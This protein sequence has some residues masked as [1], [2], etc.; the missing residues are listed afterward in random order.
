MSKECYIIV[1]D[2][3]RDNC[4]DQFKIFKN[5]ANLYFLYFKSKND[6][7]NKDYTKYGKA[8]F[9][10]DFHD[11]YALIKTIKVKKVF[12][13]SLET[14][15]EVALNVACKKTGIKTYHIEHGIRNLVSEASE[16][17]IIHNKNTIIKLL[18]PF[19]IISNIKNRRFFTNTIKNST[20]ED[21]FNLKNY[22][23]IRSVNGIEDTF[24]KVKNSYRIANHYISFSSEIYKYHFIKDHLSKNQLVNF[25]GVPEFD[26]YSSINIQ[27]KK[28]CNNIIY[29]SQPFVEKGV[30]GWTQE[31]QLSLIK[32][33]S[34][35]LEPRK[36][37]IF[38]KI[39]PKSDMIFWNKVAKDFKNIILLKDPNDLIE[40]LKFNRLIFGFSSTLL[41]PLIAQKH[42]VCFSLEKHPNGQ[43]VNSFLN[44]KEIISRL[45]SIKNL[46]FDALDEIHSQQLAHKKEFITK[47]LYKLDGKSNERFN[48]LVLNS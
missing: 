39:H 22:Y 35:F 20:N 25:I 2:Y 21:A 15:N 30:R 6:I 11:A 34:S 38:I 27:T 4:V 43:L 37:K 33:F 3:N 9:W 47:W 5:I 31:F 45:S 13:F 1:G 40:K 32:E 44:N 14:Y 46:D 28:V 19:E 48:E 18:N 17:R 29:L 26:K 7:R 36:L 42:T 16:T 24:L 41:L 8:L 10:K 23:S 12:F